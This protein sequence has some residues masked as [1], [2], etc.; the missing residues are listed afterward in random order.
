MSTICQYETT[1]S[2]FVIVYVAYM[3]ARKGEATI[4][5]TNTCYSHGDT[6]FISLK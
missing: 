1:L 5:Q 6:N 4:N 3:F 2:F